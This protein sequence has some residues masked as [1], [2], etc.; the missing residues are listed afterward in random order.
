MA[1]FA[2]GKRS[3]AISDRSGFKVPYTQLKT[4]WDNLRVEP[5]EW[6]VKHPRLTP[7]K[8]IIDPTALLDPRPDNDPEEIIIFL[9]YNWLNTNTTSMQATEYN[10]PNL[11]V[12]KGSVGFVTFEIINTSLSGIEASSAFGTLVLSSEI[13]ASGA[14][15]TGA[16][17][18]ET[19]AIDVTGVSG[20]AGTGA[21]RV[22]ALNLSITEAGVAGTGAV[23]VEALEASI[24]EAGIA[25]TGAVGTEDA[26]VDETFWG[27]GDWNEGAWGQ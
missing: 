7:P 5:E 8:N 27:S 24:T 26:Q 6:E 12:A 2:K 22:E 11:P 3:Q 16:V 23:G 9:N 21:V 13:G 25:G 20:T 4:T 14:A 19:F 1:R 18:T 15:G 17:G 10:K